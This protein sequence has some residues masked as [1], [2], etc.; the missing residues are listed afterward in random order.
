MTERPPQEA[1]ALLENALRRS[2][3]TGSVRLPQ[4]FA[5]DRRARD[6]DPPLP[7]LISHGGIQLRVLLVVL[8]MATSAPHNTKVSSKDLA[9]M[10]DLPDPERAGARRVSKALKDLEAAQLVRRDRKPGYVPETTV[11]HPSGSGAEWN[12]NKLQKPYISLPVN[13]WRRGWF[14]ALSSRA[15]ALLIVLRELTHGRPSGAAWVDPIRKAQYGLSDDTWTRASQ[16]LIDVGLL[17][18]T[19]QVYPFQGEPRRRNVYKLNLD[20]LADHD[21]GEPPNRA[22]EPQVF[23]DS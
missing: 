13:L 2:K 12:D 7:K 5:R 14:I 4:E 9:A 15:I 20:H 1:V 10:L 17:K 6:P 8:M 11:L 22:D 3:R 18:V 16:E 21:P 23:T 19:V